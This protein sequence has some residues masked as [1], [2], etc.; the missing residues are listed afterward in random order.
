MMFREIT[1]KNT[2]MLRTKRAHISQLVLRAHKCPNSVRED[3]ACAELN[4]V[5]DE[6][7]HPD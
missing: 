6:Q 4:T 7:E 1:L 5:L 3:S 2:E